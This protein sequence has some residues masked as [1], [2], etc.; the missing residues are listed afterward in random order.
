MADNPKSRS[1]GGRRWTSFE[2]LRPTAHEWITTASGLPYPDVLAEAT[3]LY[4]PIEG[5]FGDLLRT[6][7]SSADLFRAIC[8]IK[9]TSLRVQL[10]RIFRKYVSPATPVEMLK[11]TKD[12]DRILRNHGATFR[13]LARVREAYASRPH[14]DEALCAVLWEYKDRGRRGTELTESFFEEARRSLGDAFALQGGKDI[15]LV[16]LYPD[17]PNPSRGVD[18]VLRHR[19]EVVAVGYLHYDSDRGG[20]QE[21]DRPGGYRN[22]A[23]EVV[24]FIHRRGLRTKLIFVNDGPG[25]LLGSMWADYAAIEKRWPYRVM[26]L[27]LKMVPSRLT[28][29]WLLR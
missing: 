27:T 19:R 14:P 24:D 25:L 6:S 12:A 4:G 28:K 18:F 17:Y 26:V 11:R 3:R 15:P 20:A 5:A 13:P 8:A 22:A 29:A 10:A 7:A 16:R 21:D 9:K 23:D 2:S 1:F